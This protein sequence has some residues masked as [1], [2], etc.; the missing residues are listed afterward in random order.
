MGMC[1]VEAFSWGTN[2]LI[3]YLASLT[4]RGCCTIVGGADTVA[5]IERNVRSFVS[6]WRDYPISLLQGV[7]SFTHIS[8]GG[9]AT[10]E[11]LEGKVLPGVAALMK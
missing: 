7:A 9:G 8:T 1:E 2:Q 3:D 5:A 4:T 10:L 11:M 6:K